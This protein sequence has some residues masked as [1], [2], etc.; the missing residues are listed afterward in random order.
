MSITDILK[1]NEDKLFLPKGAVR[2]AFDKE[3]CT[4]FL[5]RLESFDFDIDRYKQLPISS[6]YELVILLD[7]FSRHV[8][9]NDQT[10][11][12]KLCSAA[13]ILA[14]DMCQKDEDLELPFYQRLYVLLA[15]RHKNTYEDLIY[16]K[17]RARSYFQESID[18]LIR[19]ERFMKKTQRDLKVFPVLPEDSVN[20][21]DAVY[22]DLL[23][24]NSTWKPVSPMPLITKHQM[25]SH[26]LKRIAHVQMKKVVLSL[27][28]G[29][30]SMVIFHLL[31]ASKIPFVCVHIDFAH[32]NESRYEA[33]FV[34]NYCNTHNIKC[35]Y[36][37]I[38][39]YSRNKHDK[40][41]RPAY[42]RQTKEERL[43]FIRTIIGQED[44]QAVIFGHHM[45]DVIEN[46]FTN[47]MLSR[48]I[49]DIGVCQEFKNTDGIMMWR[50]FLEFDKNDIYDIAHTYQIPYFKNTTPLWCNR[51]NFRDTLMPAFEQQ[52]GESIPSIG[53][54]NLSEQ[55]SALAKTI[56]TNLIDPYLKEVFVRHAM[57]FPFRKDFDALWQEIIITVFHRQGISAPSQ[58]AIRN[59]I[60]LKVGT[61]CSMRK[62]MLCYRCS[63][64]W[65]IVDLLKFKEKLELKS[66]IKDNNSC[67]HPFEHLVRYGYYGFE[68]KG[69]KKKKTNGKR[70]PFGSLPPSIREC[71][72]RGK[73]I[74]IG[75]KC[76]LI[77]NA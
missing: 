57:W 12:D 5:E 38:D 32:R 61:S 70:L 34:I 41:S 14:N 42:E 29:V 46:V 1:I 19:F 50:P 15:I 8:F 45:D 53:F 36:R 59:M 26:L 47:I 31:K 11:L 48:S 35:F 17:R 9:R 23:D 13:N 21:D 54:R 3:L 72:P 25:L 49:L 39:E 60:N 73:D 77:L 51:R 18:D 4:L 64:G 55:S 33:E 69:K 65:I 52:Y 7:Q 22:F 58:I 2:D 27:S 37:R 67:D 28:G 43:S 40:L 10:T 30:D 6:K 68:M 66:E 63:N 16:C 76:N 44:A 24:T 62:N 74:A 75:S 56:R 71:I 20:K